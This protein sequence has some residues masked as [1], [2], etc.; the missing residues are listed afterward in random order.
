MNSLQ[1]N[2]AIPHLLESGLLL[3]S[4]AGFGALE[5]E[6]FAAILAEGVAEGS[7]RIGEEA[8]TDTR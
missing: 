4:G 8:E 3:A 2:R 6:A 7:A 1:A 5:S